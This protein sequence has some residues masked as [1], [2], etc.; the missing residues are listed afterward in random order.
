[1]RSLGGEATALA[2][3]VLIIDDDLDSSAEVGAM[4]ARAS[5]THV[6]APNGQAALELIGNGCRPS[7]ALVDLRMPTLGGLAFARRL[8]QFH[9]R[10]RP[11]LVF[12]SGSANF[13]DATEALRLGARDML[14][15]PVDGRQL[16]KAVKDARLHYLSRQPVDEDI[17]VPHA[18]ETSSGPPL[19]AEDLD[20]VRAAVLKLRAIGQARAKHLPHDLF[21]D[22]C[23]DML[24]DLYHCALT[25]TEATVTSLGAASGVPLTTALRRMD[26]LQALGLVARSR[27]DSDKRRIVMSLTESGVRAIESYLADYIK[28]H[29]APLQ[30]DRTS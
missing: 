20:K 17:P 3:D 11:E 5:L 16:V 10:H 24:L 14:T 8:S 26:D 1:M 12:F 28:R 2:T 19:G 23:W 15:K 13:N 21:A 18:P 30:A 6:M 4:L 27:N 29:Q 7:V 9:E 22:P 25:H